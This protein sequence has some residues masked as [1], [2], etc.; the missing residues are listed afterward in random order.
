MA[1]RCFFKKPVFQLYFVRPADKKQSAYQKTEY[2][3]GTVIYNDFDGMYGF[4]F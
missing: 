2:I 4:F 1:L 3:K